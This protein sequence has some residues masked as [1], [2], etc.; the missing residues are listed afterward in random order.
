MS[1]KLRAVTFKIT[2]NQIRWLREA[3]EKTGLNQVEIVRR[4]LDAYEYAERIKE[5]R[6]LF[7][8]QQRREIRTIAR[9]H[10]LSE[11]EAARE[12]LDAGLIRM[13]EKPIRR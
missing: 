9:R 6:R 11:F 4:A 3:S 7:T 2:E 12:T 10:G 13:S 5:E 8:P 1:N